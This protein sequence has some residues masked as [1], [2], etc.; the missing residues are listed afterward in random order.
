ML[1]RLVSKLK[2]LMSEMAYSIDVPKYL[3]FFIYKAIFG[4]SSRDV[5][6]DKSELELQTRLP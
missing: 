2:I 3:W 5:Q 4:L 6:D 1:P